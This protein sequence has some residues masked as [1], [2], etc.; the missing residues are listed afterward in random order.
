MVSA[1]VGVAGDEVL[2][3]WLAE[4]KNTKNT[5][6]RRSDSGEIPANSG[7]AE[8]GLGGGAA[9]RAGVVIR[10]HNGEWVA[11]CSNAYEEA[12]IPELA[13]VMVVRMALTFAK[14]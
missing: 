11:A 2:P 4:V 12:I 3:Q 14:E 1:V 6:R 7:T 10:D 9:L 8:E 13:E 5:A